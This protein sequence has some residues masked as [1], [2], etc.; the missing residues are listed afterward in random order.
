MSRR[1]ARVQEAE[2]FLL[3]AYPW[4]ETSVVAH[5]FAKEHGVVVAVAKGAKRPYSVMRPILSHF[6]PLLLSWSGQGEVKTL[7]R[8][9]YNGF[10]PIQGRALMPA[11]YMNELLLKFLAPEDPHPEL[12]DMYSECLRELAEG[13]NENI[14]LRRFEWA[15]LEQTGYGFADPQPDFYDP[16]Q[17]LH[18]RKRMRQRLD[19]QLDQ[20][21]LK[22]RDV[23]QSLHRLV[24]AHQ[25]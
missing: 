12:F 6:H 11:W 2:A 8:A 18:W 25:E 9:E 17:N 16:A 7:T 5:V 24:R 14:V 21:E 13:L 22:T 23:I 4:S 19:E 1:K 10:F 20:R 3:N 15:L